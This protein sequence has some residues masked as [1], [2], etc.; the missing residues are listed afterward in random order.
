MSDFKAKMHEIRFPLGLCPRA[1]RRSL[2][3]C[4]WAPLAVLKVTT[5]TCKR[6][7]TIRRGK[8]TG[9]KSK[10]ETRRGMRGIWPTQKF[11]RGAPY[12]A[13]SP[14]GGPGNHS[15]SLTSF[16]PYWPL[17]ILSCVLL[18]RED[19]PRCTFRDCALTL[20]CTYAQTLVLQSY[21]TI[22]T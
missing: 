7:K 9:T 20:S 16:I 21:L 13:E 1:R 5:S 18:V 22:L 4:I 3:S 17:S 12:A 19:Q 15:V 8:A 10:R 2:F 6:R 14:S 11:W